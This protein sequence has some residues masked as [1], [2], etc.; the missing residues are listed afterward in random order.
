MSCEHSTRMHVLAIFE[1]IENAGKFWEH[2]GTID[3]DQLRIISSTSQHLISGDSFISDCAH[4]YSDNNNEIKETET[5]LT[6]YPLYQRVSLKKC[7]EDCVLSKHRVGN[8]WEQDW[9]KIFF[10]STGIV[11][12]RSSMKTTGLPGTWKAITNK[13]SV[14]YWVYSKHFPASHFRGLLSMSE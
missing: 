13:C 1:N 8:F 2:E 3:E 9:T 14:L 7:T 5:I 12:V 11:A 4:R 6:I 10:V